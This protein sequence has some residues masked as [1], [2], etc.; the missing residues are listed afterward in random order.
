MS[1]TTRSRRTV[2]PAC[3]VKTKRASMVCCWDCW[4]AVPFNIRARFAKADTQ[5]RLLII[6][7][8][9]EAWNCHK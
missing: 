5:E 8:L 3:G 4:Q 6:R 7:A 9:H 1:E 2:C